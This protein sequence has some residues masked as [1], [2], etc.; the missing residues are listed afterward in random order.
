VSTNQEERDERPCRFC[1]AAYG[2]D[3]ELCEFAHRQS[4][5]VLAPLATAMARL[6]Q[7]R[8]PSDEQVGWFMED[9]S[10]VVEDFDP[11]PDKWR[12]RTLPTSPHDGFVARFRIND[13]TYVIEDGEG[14]CTPVRLATLRQ[15]Q[16]EA[17]AP[18]AAPVPVT[19][20]RT[21]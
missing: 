14:H 17:D 1:R 19:E 20:G 6:F 8:N 18:L 5:E 13:V 16:R 7:G 12:L 9:A 10:A 2:D 15:W 21:E 3:A 4:A 11:M